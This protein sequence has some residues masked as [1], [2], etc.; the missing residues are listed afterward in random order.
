MLLFHAIIFMIVTVTTQ[1]IFPWGVLYVIVT[2]LSVVPYISLLL[3]LSLVE[4]ELQ[5]IGKLLFFVSVATS[6]S[7]IIIHC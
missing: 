7:K 4:G 3:L 1:G 2:L 6:V 5:L